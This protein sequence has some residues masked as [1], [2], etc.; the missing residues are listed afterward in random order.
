MLLRIKLYVYNLTERLQPKLTNTTHSWVFLIIQV[1]QLYT[2]NHFVISYQ[3]YLSLWHLRSVHL[4]KDKRNI[5][6]ELPSTSQLLSSQI[7]CNRYAFDTQNLNTSSLILPLPTSVTAW[8][9]NSCS[10]SITLLVWVHG[11]RIKI[12]WQKA[13]NTG[14]SSSKVFLN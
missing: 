8:V 14:H 3:W 11:S 1:R 10:W 12:K 6:L 7:D 5:W 4:V 13:L 9:S 2:F